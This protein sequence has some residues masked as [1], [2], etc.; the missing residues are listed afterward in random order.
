MV[1]KKENDL[2]KIKEFLTLVENP[3][4]ELRHY[5]KPVLVWAV[6]EGT[7]F[8]SF[9]EEEMLTRFGLENVDGWDFHEDLLFCPDWIGDTEEEDLEDFDL[10]DEDIEELSHFLHRNMD[11]KD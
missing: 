6:D 3:K 9:W 5:K 10:D 8:Y 4:V 7:V 11:D 2:R 1:F